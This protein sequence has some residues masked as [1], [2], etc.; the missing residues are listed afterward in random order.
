M[1]EC[2]QTLDAKILAAHAAEDGSELVTL[3]S[4]AADLSSDQT[5][6]AFYLTHAFVFALEIADKRAME[7]QTRLASMGAL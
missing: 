2:R 7:L 1:N 5:A 6:Q 3:Y 4:M